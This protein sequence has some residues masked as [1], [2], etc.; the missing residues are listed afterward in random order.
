[1]FDEFQYAIPNGWFPFEE[2]PISYSV[3]P[4]MKSSQD[5]MWGDTHLGIEPLHPRPGGPGDVTSFRE[6]I[7]VVD[8]TGQNQILDEFQYELAIPGGTMSVLY[9]EN[10]HESGITTVKGYAL[11]LVDGSKYLIFFE[12]GEPTAG[13]PKM[14][15]FLGTISIN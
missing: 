12:F 13:V 4:G 1:M 10:A 15:Q 14:K 2:G 11:V 3:P 9:N 8:T 7:Q 6:F 5:A